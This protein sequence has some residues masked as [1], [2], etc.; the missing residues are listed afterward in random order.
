MKYIKF[1]SLLLCVVILATMLS[2]CKKDS[3][4]TKPIIAVSIVPEATFVSAVCGD[5]CDVVTMI[6]SGA[7][8]ENYAPTPLEI[9]EF[10]DSVIYFSIGVPTEENNIM[11]NV[12]ENTKVVHLE[13]EVATIYPDLKLG[14]DRDPHIWLSPKR[15]VLMIQ[16]I[17]REL[18]ALYPDQTDIFKAN[19]DAFIAQINQIDTEI[20]TILQSTTSKA[21][22]VFHPAFGYLAND[23]GLTMY[24]LEEEGKEATPQHLQEMIDFAKENNIKVIF[25]QEEIDASQS[26]SFAEEID[27]KTACL[28][29]LSAD[30][31][32]NLR[33]MADTLADALN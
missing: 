16:I 25:Y 33:I 6:P 30:Y 28:A 26:D 29:P 24:A 2:A 14:E 27:G 9:E 19:A 21:F 5:Y 11:P 3:G 23:Y 32:S 8:P 13:T 12:T 22:I 1:F 10:S 18:S 4:S 20:N 7:S 31:I 17:E 15:V